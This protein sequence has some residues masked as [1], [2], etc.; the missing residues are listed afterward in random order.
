MC[1]VVRV[2][3]ARQAQSSPAR[4]QFLVYSVCVGALFRRWVSLSLKVQCSKPA[5]HIGQAAVIVFCTPLFDVNYSIK[6]ARFLGCFYSHF[7]FI[8]LFLS[9][10]YFQYFT[11]PTCS[12]FS[13]FRFLGVCR[14]AYSQK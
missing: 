13:F 3:V 9:V 1:Q 11:T 6:N 8:V 5:H 12:I 10:L 4:R 2:S 7:F 14:Y